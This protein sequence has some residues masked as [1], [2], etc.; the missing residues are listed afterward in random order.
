MWKKGRKT[1]AEES[2]E[3]QGVMKTGRNMSGW[4]GAVVGGGGWGKRLNIFSGLTKNMNNNKN[5][6]KLKTRIISVENIWE[7]INLSPVSVL[8]FWR[9]QIRRVCVCMCLH[10]YIL[11][12]CVCLRKYQGVVSYMQALS[13]HG[14]P[15]LGFSK[16]CGNFLNIGAVRSRFFHFWGQTFF[17]LKVLWKSFDNHGI[18]E[19]KGL[20]HIST[21]TAKSCV[22]ARL[23]GG[24]RILRRLFT[25][26]ETEGWG[27]AA[28][29]GHTHFTSTD[30]LQTRWQQRT[31]TIFQWHGMI[32]VKNGQ[33]CHKNTLFFSHVGDNFRVKRLFLFLADRAADFPCR[34]HIMKLKRGWN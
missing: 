14:F 4:R 34:S 17:H 30:S 8:L 6:K 19:D 16:S 29:G 33:I 31:H 3:I 1:E 28:G 2:R 13:T 10:S 9:R 23:H 22:T 32:Y 20:S 5:K 18:Q 27:A 15:L 21:Y 25:A 26:A 7:D 24:R 12:V 11:C